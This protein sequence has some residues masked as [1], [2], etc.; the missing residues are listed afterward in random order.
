MAALVN[1]AVQC[2]MGK[3][4]VAERPRHHLACNEYLAHQ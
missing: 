3:V 2:I 1:I 4:M